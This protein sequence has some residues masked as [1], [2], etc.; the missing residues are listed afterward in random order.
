MLCHNL[1]LSKGIH[2]SGVIE[3]LAHGLAGACLLLDDLFVL[4]V[5][6]QTSLFDQGQ[7]GT[8]IGV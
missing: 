2:H 8:G 7:Q 3:H 6:N 1:E 4:E 5:V